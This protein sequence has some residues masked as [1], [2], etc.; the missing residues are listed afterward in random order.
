MQKDIENIIERWVIQL[1][2]RSCILSCLYR[3]FFCGN[4]HLL[5]LKVNWYLISPYFLLAPNRHSLIEYPFK[6]CKLNSPTKWRKKFLF[7]C[8]SYRVT[9]EGHSCVTNEFEDVSV[10]SLVAWWLFLGFVRVRTRKVV[11]KSGCPPIST[12]LR[13][14]KINKRRKSIK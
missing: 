1:P 4:A 7:V 11:L 10:G 3:P 9:I 8:R 2:L 6:V 5:S 13:K 12:N 14:T